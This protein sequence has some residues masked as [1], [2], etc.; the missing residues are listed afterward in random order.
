MSRFS[1]MPDMAGVLAWARKIVYGPGYRRERRAAFQRSGGMCQL[2]GL[3]PAAEAH[4]WAWCQ[5][6]RIPEGI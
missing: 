1:T 4:H 2:C 6:S 5:R 3:F